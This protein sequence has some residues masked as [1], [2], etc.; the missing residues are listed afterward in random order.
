MGKEIYFR[1]IGWKLEK[2]M[3]DQIPLRISHFKESGITDEW[4]SLTERKFPPLPLKPF[5]LNLE[6]NVIVQFYCVTIGL[7]VAFLVFLI[8]E[9]KLIWG[10]ISI[11]CKRIGIGFIC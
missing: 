7:L 1:K 3:D 9:V 8:E 10:C 6:G 11:A 5:Q 4:I 2:W